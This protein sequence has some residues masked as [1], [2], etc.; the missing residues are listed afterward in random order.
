MSFLTQLGFK[1]RAYHDWY[2]WV[3]GYILLSQQLK[4]VSRWEVFSI[5][6]VR[7]SEAIQ[8]DAQKVSYICDIALLDA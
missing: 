2:F 3:L 1:Y 5:A 8:D 7:L 6:G 4:C